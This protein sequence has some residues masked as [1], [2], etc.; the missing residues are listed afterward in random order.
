MSFDSWRQP[1]QVLVAGLSLLLA[2]SLMG[3]EQPT[4]LRIQQSRAAL[5]SDATGGMRGS[6]GNIYSLGDNPATM[7][8]STYPNTATCLLIYSDGKYVFEKRDE[9]TIGRPKVKT[10]E[11]SLSED[12]LQKLRSILGN[13]DLQKITKIE[14]VEPPSDVVA[15]RE[16]ETLDI[17]INRDGV[18]QRLIATKERF[19]VQGTGTAGAS[20]GASTG[21]DKF[22][23]NAAPYRK[24]LNPLMK[25][26][27]EVEK[28]SK[29]SL[30][31][32]QPKYCMP[33]IVQ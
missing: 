10:A 16:A 8:V 18:M 2:P 13:E 7:G 31:E 24:T 5:D 1:A 28:K 9:H 11:G 27:G 19:K 23:D 14:A 15:L 32:S 3:Q 4:L 6:G 12:D 26:F 20:T 17:R 25:W 21:M 33:M 22:L 30:K 29:S